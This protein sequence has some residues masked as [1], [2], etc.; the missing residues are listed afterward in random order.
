MKFYVI[1]FGSFFGFIRAMLLAMLFAGLAFPSGAQHK[2]ELFS[3][4]DL[5]LPPNAKK[6]LSRGLRLVPS[7]SAIRDIYENEPESFLLGIPLPDGT[8]KEF[9][10]YKTHV[11]TD[12]FRVTTSDGKEFRGKKFSGVHYQIR[13]GQQKENIGAISFS[14][15]EVAGIFSDERGNWNLGPLPDGN[16]DYVVFCERDLLVNSGFHCSTPE[17]DVKNPG[18]NHRLPGDNKSTQSTGTCKVVK[19]YFECDFKMYQD[20]GSNT[21][22]TSSKI[23]SMFSMVQQLFS[24]EQIAVELDQ[25]FVW[26]STDPYATTTTSGAILN[27]FTTN[28][29]SITQKLG[30]FVSTRPAGMGGIAWLDV[31]CNPSFYIYRF[32][33]S[34]IYNTFSAVP[35]YSWSV[36]CMTHEIG[37]NFGSNHTHWCGWTG[38]AIDNCY[39]T[40]PNGASTCA[41]GPAVSNGGTIMSYCHTTPAGINFTKGFGTQP[42]NRIRTGFAC[43]SGSPV[44]A[45]SL[46]SNRSVCTGES[47]S[48]GAS[49]SSSG[50]TFAWTGPNGFTSSQ[51]NPVIGTATAAAAGD[52][53][54]KVAAAGCTSDAKI[55]NVVVNT[56]A[57]PPINEGFTTSSFPP[58]NWRINNPNQDITWV[59]NTTAGGFGTSANSMSIDN[60]TAP[61]T[62]GKRDTIFLPVMD[63]SGQTGASLEFDVAHRWNGSSHDTLCVIASG[64]CGR[65]FQRLY[66]K[67]GSALSTVTGSTNSK[68][69][70]T[71]TQWRK[72]TISLS[73]YNGQSKVQVAFAVFSGASNMLYVDNVNLT[74]SSGSS[75]TITLSALSQSSYCPGQVLSIG[76]TTS[77]TFNNGN[78]FQVELSNSSGSFSNPTVIGSG[79]ASPVSATIPAGATS[80]SGY[81]IRVVS[82]NPSIASGSSQVLSIA[83]LIVA[84]GVDQSVCSN[85][86]FIT[87]TG[88]PLGGTWSGTGVSASGIFIPSAGLVGNQTLTYSVTSGGCSGTDQ[89]VVTVK[90]VPSVNAGT[91]QS[92]CSQTAAFALTGFSP[93]GG[94]WSGNGV[95]ASGTFT[96]SS[97]LV[98]SNTL[99][100]S[101]TQNGCTGTDTKLVT[102]TATVPVS[103]GSAQSVCSNGTAINLSGSP[104]GGIWSGNGISASG[105]FIPTSSLT[106]SN[107]VTYTISGN[108]AGS[109][110]TTVTVNAAPVVQS[111]SDRIVC[112]LVAPFFIT[113]AQPQGG[114]WTGSGVSASGFFTPQSSMVGSTVKLIYTGQQNGCQA[115]DSLLIQVLDFPVSASISAPT[116]EACS[117]DSIRLS[118]SAVGT[119]L[120]F[121]W[122]R[123]GVNI[124]GANAALLDAVQSG[125]YLAGIS[126]ASCN[127]N[128]SEKVLVFNPVPATP[129]ITVAGNELTSSSASGNQWQLNGVNIP[130]ATGQIYVAEQ[131]GLYSVLATQANC[132]SQ[133]SAGVQVNITGFEVP[134][135]SAD[136]WLLSPNPARDKIF[137]SCKCQLPEFHL[138]LLDATGRTLRTFDGKASGEAQ[139]LDI[140][141]LP[142][143][144]YWLRA[145]DFSKSRFIR[146]VMIQ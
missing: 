138:N 36:Y 63:L 102:V 61:S 29:Q 62:S 106:G 132:S 117:G 60:F 96:P 66:K 125:T 111:G 47:I 31:V 19:M 116:P 90:A 39:Q 48:L 46:R 124:P 21:A 38:G 2:A 12:D 129:V 97:T 8:K 35:T 98:G 72:E 92:T 27:S 143:G 73:A 85:G 99:T 141:G 144:V 119:G 84:G 95:S 113:G 58:S 20:N 82:G 120:Q 3:A 134:D 51:Q 86:S 16:G 93:S 65:S 1:K 23:S 32:G 108:C 146:K 11:V 89:V 57:A 80:G 68:F 104:A 81:R 55:T 127:L 41:S 75:N 74:A 139:T 131:P 9:V 126:R 101:F 107:T 28:R 26:T 135:Q 145:Q 83:P 123:N 14:E 103:A 67:S 105:V 22:N 94:T 18:N 78:T 7:M 56:A 110:Q 37:H 121:Q 43:I 50:A 5:P 42:G 49:T 69:V 13:P 40:E 118:L 122:R 142:A 87:L 15:N 76:F 30:H 59:R 52:Y 136:H 140:S 137:I 109:A 114:I 100:Y 91:D 133:P 112:G 25:V 115:K 88:T 45:F 4:S 44:P 130:G 64:D 34:N 10:F 70:P 33:F 71:A 79:A 24:N 54:C 128:S 77:G 6:G 53:S 17:S